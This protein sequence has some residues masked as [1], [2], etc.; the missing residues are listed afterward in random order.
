[1]VI[2]KVL[3]FLYWLSDMTEGSIVF[4]VTEKFNISPE[5]ILTFFFKL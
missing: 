3:R 5:A 2:F 1:M 4:I